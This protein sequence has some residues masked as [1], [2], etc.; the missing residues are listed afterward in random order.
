MIHK[1]IIL[2]PTGQ[3]KTQTI[4]APMAQTLLPGQLAKMAAGKLQH[5]LQGDKGGLYVLTNNS[6]FG[7]TV[8]DPIVEGDNGVGVFM[9][10]DVDYAVLLKSATGGEFPAGTICRPG[11]F[12]G[13]VQPSSSP[14]EYDSLVTREDVVLSPGVAVLVAMRTL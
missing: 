8:I 13:I 10:P 12:D 2:G 1:K 5:V 14:G 9:E 3:N 6:L 11:A 7:G 4:E